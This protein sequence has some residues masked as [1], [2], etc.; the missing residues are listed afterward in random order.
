[1]PG[2][3]TIVQVQ[4]PVYSESTNLTLS[5]SDVTAVT[6]TSSDVTI[7]NTSAA[8]ISL[9]TSTNLSNSIPMELAEVGDA[10]VSVLA[11]RSDHVHPVINLVLN[12]GNF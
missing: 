2:D 9:P 12:G 4:S 11:S 6:V 3:I 1:M 8:T 10:G 5:D 7:L